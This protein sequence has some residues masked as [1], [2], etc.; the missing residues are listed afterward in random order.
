MGVLLRKIAARIVNE[1]RPANLSDEHDGVERDERE[2]ELTDL[3]SESDEET[4]IVPSRRAR[5]L[6]NE[7]SQERGSSQGRE[8]WQI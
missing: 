2:D 1:K 6:G 7:V 3:N 5:D 4:W 8:Y